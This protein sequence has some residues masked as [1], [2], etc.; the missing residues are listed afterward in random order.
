MSS[1]KSFSCNGKGGVNTSLNR[2]KTLVGGFYY[3]HIVR[4]S[5]ACSRTQR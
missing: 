3:K 2:K 5:L 4:Y 1:D